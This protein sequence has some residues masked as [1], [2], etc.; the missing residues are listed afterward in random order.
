MTRQTLITNLEYW[1]DCL[2]NP[3]YNKLETGFRHTPLSKDEIIERYSEMLQFLKSDIL[4]VL[5]EIKKE[6]SE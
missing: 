4:A 1:V 6:D 5:E 2:E 3:A